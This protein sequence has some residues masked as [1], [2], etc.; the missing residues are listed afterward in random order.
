MNDTEAPTSAEMAVQQMLELRQRGQL[1]AALCNL[2][3]LG[4]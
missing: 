2:R 1:V 3:T 4:L